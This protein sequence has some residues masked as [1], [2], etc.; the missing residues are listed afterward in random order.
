MAVRRFSDGKLRRLASGAL[1]ST[2]ALS[3][4]GT[5]G[6]S[7]GGTTTVTPAAVTAPSFGPLTIS[8]G[9]FVAP[10]GQPV[11][12]AGAHTWT[13]LQN[14]DTTNYPGQSNGGQ[15]FGDAAFDQLLDADGL[16]ASRF[17][18]WDAMVDGGGT[19]GPVSPTPWVVT[20][21]KADLTQIN[22]ALTARVRSVAQRFI[23]GQKYPI[24]QAGANGTSYYVTT[25][26]TGWEANPFKA[27]NNSNGIDGANGGSD[28]TYALQ[29][30]SGPIW[31]AHVLLLH[32]II[33]AVYDLPEVILEVPGNELADDGA[34]RAFRA[35]M[36]AEAKS[37]LASKGSSL[38]VTTSA[39]FPPYT[40]NADANSWQENS[41]GAVAYSLAGTIY[42]ATRGNQA[43]YN[44]PDEPAADEAK[45]VFDDDD[46]V[47]GGGAWVP[48][49]AF[50]QGYAVLLDMESMA[51]IA[52]SLIPNSTGGSVEAA[53]RAGMGLA[54]KLAGL[55]SL[56]GCSPQPGL[57][58]N[59]A[60]VRCFANP[61]TGTYLVYG[62]T[63][64]TVN[65]SGFGPQLGY[66]TVGSDGTVSAAS[67]VVTNGSAVQFSV[68]PGGVLIIQ[69]A[70]VSV[71]AASSGSLS[72]L[73]ATG[74]VGTA[75]TGTFA[76]TNASAGYV[77]LQVGGVDQGSPVQVT[78]AS[79][80]Y[81]LTP[82]AA[83]TANAVLTL[84]QAG[85]QV[86]WT[87]AA[88][89]VAAQQQQQGGGSGPTLTAGITTPA[90]APAGALTV[91]AGQQYATLAAAVAAAPAGATIAVKDSAT[92][93]NDWPGSIN[94]NITI[95][96]FG[97]GA[98]PIFTF[99]GNPPNQK[100]FIDHTGGNLLLEYLEIENV[101]W[102][103]DQNGAG[104]RN[105]GG[106]GTL[107][108]CKIHDCDM[109]VL[110]GVN[111]GTYSIDIETCEIYKCG[112]QPVNGNPNSH[113]I[114][115][116]GDG[117]G[118]SFTLNNSYVHDANVGHEVK[119][120]AGN[121]TITNNRI[122]DNQGSASYSIDVPQ[123]GA[124]TITGNIIQQGTNTGNPV[125]CAY[126]EEVPTVPA[127]PGAAI[128]FNNN[129]VVNDLGSSSATLWYVEGGTISASGNTL[130]GL[131][132][133]Q[134]GTSNSS[135]APANSGYTYT[136]TRPT[137][138]TTPM[139][140]T[141]TGGA[142]ETITLAQPPA[143]EAGASFQ[144]SGT[145]ANPPASP[146]LQALLG[147][148]ALSGTAT[149]AN[150][151][152]TFTALVPG[153]GAGTIS[154]QMKDSTT[155]VL[156]NTVSVS[157]AAQQGGGTVSTGG[158]PVML[159]KGPVAVGDVL[160]FGHTFAY[161]AIPSGTANTLTLSS[162]GASAGVQVGL[163]NAWP[164]GSLRVGSCSFRSPVAIASGAVASF[165]WGTSS[166]LTGSGPTAQQL[167]AM[168][169]IRIQG[170]GGASQSLNGGGSSVSFGSDTYQLDVNAVLAS[171]PAWNPSTGYGANPLCG[172]EELDTGPNRTLW[173]VWSFAQRTSDGAY[174]RYVKLT[175]YVTALSDGAGGI[176]GAW[177]YGTVRQPNL[178][179]PHPSATL[180]TVSGCP[181]YSNNYTALD[182]K[183]GATLF[184]KG[185]VLTGPGSFQAL[186]NAQAMPSWIAGTRSGAA[187]GYAPG[188][189]PVYAM[190][191]R[192][193]PPY[194]QTLIGLEP[195]DA[196]VSTYSCGTI[197]GI[198]PIS[199]SEFGILGTTG[200]SPGDE[201]IGVLNGSSVCVLLNPLNTNRVVRQKSYCFTSFCYYF[202][203]DDERTGRPFGRTP[204][205]YPGLIANPSLNMLGAVATGNPAWG[206]TSVQAQDP[207]N[208]QNRYQ[209]NIDAS[210]M[211]SHWIVPYFLTGHPI[212]SDLGLH[213]TL[214]MLASQPVDCCDWPYG[215]S[216]SPY[217][218][219]IIAPNAMQV[220]G[221]GWANRQLGF[222]ECL[223]PDADPHR[224]LV[225][226]AMDA[227][228]Q[229]M[230]DVVTTG[231]IP[232]PILT[233]GLLPYWKVDNSQY[234][235]YMMAYM[236]VG[237]G[238]NAYR[239]AVS[240]T[241][242]GFA[243]WL[244]A[245]KPALVDMWDENNG[246]TCS[247]MD[248]YLV[249]VYPSG[250]S[251][252][253]SMTGAYPTLAAMRS[254]DQ[255]ANGI[256]SLPAPKGFHATPAVNFLGNSLPLPGNAQCFAGSVAAGV[257]SALTFC[258]LIGVPNA[259]NVYNQ[260]RARMTDGSIGEIY[261]T[262]FY[263][264]A[265]GE[266]ETAASHALVIPPGM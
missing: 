19:Y 116:T 247:L 65:L 128:T 213:E 158:L 148:T 50:M 150:G 187:P 203:W 127:N 41:S 112:V 166:A 207:L 119:V 165:Q 77:R 208:F 124:A 163:Q 261:P 79:G 24:I 106:A 168:S 21:G 125:I 173:R 157:V 215:P 2:S 193:M 87:S 256:T 137:T 229:F 162:G 176:A 35:A 232:A 101:H 174:D 244:N 51:S 117:A 151:N 56:Q 67:Q 114:Y 217:N 221:Y 136:S 234:Q 49:D 132:S 236:G 225:K 54:R 33:D 202:C 66:R 15:A 152:T 250:A 195:Q 246:G 89:T 146:V 62:D 242:P 180:G 177:V 251:P 240:N 42:T 171:G 230:H 178:Y 55:V 104:Y 9:M 109:G 16:N 249:N 45:P 11:L 245:C 78:G 222:T 135:P 197:A 159:F 140:A 71:T 259:R 204:V 199:G 138:D 149:L 84:D 76:L 161:S 243:A 96:A 265:Y 83:E 82:T 257:S 64:P 8:G 129:T 228:S 219:L 92:Y 30:T 145:I 52:G 14:I 164:D 3:N 167:A 212:F 110:G 142:P 141:A 134:L 143:Q 206:F 239:E 237:V 29:Q 123:G 139:F 183:S 38:L 36:I 120:R 223:L 133:G 192:V 99:T 201:R 98:L 4:A 22:P 179:G 170:T 258:A 72:P 31:N 57:V 93:T 26:G 68:P 25:A 107:R 18:I 126:G 248:D 226:D 27:G 102:S 182:A 160:E 155:G 172:Y 111:N 69:P 20:N 218:N 5:S 122:F 186:A 196:A 46:H 241:R 263:S 40:S 103:T 169:D 194:D 88:I 86:L 105:E 144:I 28:G 130:Y 214:T 23:A 58:G 235:P 113:N 131:T 175:A 211:P 260:A 216:P 60:G 85:T 75:I 39:P 63:S 191:T 13:N 59:A 231:Y 43:G 6:G 154:L 48:V 44:T 253:D 198:D 252:N 74:T 108:N 53:N 7:Y 205:N 153:Q 118:G 115:C 233:L 90:M 224:Q 210:H 262:W 95:T 91:G 188:P 17:W 32:A 209:A 100:A 200:D 254:A 184:S 264:S 220:R 73:P 156:S 189:D 10:N 121:V 266:Q 190:S 47:I 238:L 97:G 255:A 147:G 34:T 61:S 81:S 181:C 12:L 80:S 227:N 37:Y 94:Q 70:T 1:L 185:S